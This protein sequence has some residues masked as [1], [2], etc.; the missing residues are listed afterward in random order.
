[1]TFA[2]ANITWYLHWKVDHSYHLTRLPYIRI[3]LFWFRCVIFDTLENVM[4]RH[5]A[6][7]KYCLYFRKRIKVYLY[8]HLSYCQKLE[9]STF[10]SDY[11]HLAQHT[12]VNPYKRRNRNAIIIPSRKIQRYNDVLDIYLFHTTKNYSVYLTSKVQHIQQFYPY[13]LIDCYYFQRLEN[14]IDYYFFQQ[15]ENSIGCCY[16][17]QF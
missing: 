17:R 11:N 15:F 16:F 1:M 9:F 10:L 5:D 14:L 13:I 12:K 8:L 4:L 3:I 6:K 2:Y 7:Y